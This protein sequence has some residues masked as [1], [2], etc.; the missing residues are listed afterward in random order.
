MIE[1]IK[2]TKNAIKL[3][4]DDTNFTVNKHG[5]LCHETK[6]ADGKTWYTF[7]SSDVP[8]KQIIAEVKHWLANN[9]SKFEY[10]YKL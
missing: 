3:K 6:L 7:C 9:I 2:T 8:Q 5:V 4:Y 1:I 10:E